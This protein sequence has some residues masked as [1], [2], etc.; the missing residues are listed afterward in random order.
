MIAYNELT[1]GM[2]VEAQKYGVGGTNIWV[3]ATIAGLH[4]GT[5]LALV[6]F[7]DDAELVYLSMGEISP[8]PEGG[9]G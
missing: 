9:G 6:R 7:G 3:P 5:N 4:P 8:K 2:E 1:V